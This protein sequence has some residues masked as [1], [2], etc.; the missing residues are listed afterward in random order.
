[1]CIVTPAHWLA[2]HRWD[3]LFLPVERTGRPRLRLFCRRCGALTSR[4]ICDRPDR[5]PLVS[6]SPLSCPLRLCTMTHV[7]W[8]VCSSTTCFATPRS[9]IC[10]LEPRTPSPHLAFN[11]QYVLFARPLSCICKRLVLRVVQSGLCPFVQETP[12]GIA[13]QIY[14]YPA[15]G[16]GCGPVGALP[17]R[18][19][20]AFRGRRA[21]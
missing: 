15:G 13:G 19:G 16:S 10:G 14:L 18:S 12:S 1:M 6:T 9:E 11:K 5:T 17:V 21:S 4:D 20:D 3:G 8:V 2:G 7:S